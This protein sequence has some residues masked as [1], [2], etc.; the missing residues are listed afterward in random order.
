MLLFL[1][2]LAAVAVWVVRCYF[3]PFTSCRRCRGKRTNPGSS[4]KRWGPCK[5]CG[6]TG[7]RQVLGSKTV[8]RVVRDT[9]TY[10]CNRKDR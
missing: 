4:R 5:V 3:W 1:I 10:H 9:L 2:V 7:Q 8:H 6:G